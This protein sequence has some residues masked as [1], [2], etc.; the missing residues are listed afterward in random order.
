MSLAATSME[1]APTPPDSETIT[2]STA[3][4]DIR[5]QRG[6]VAI[7]FKELY[8]YRELLLFPHLA[9]CEGALQANGPGLCLGDHPAGDERHHSGGDFRNGRGF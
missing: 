9:R 2:D 6:W 4:F 5:P 3:E 1:T 8:H 7:D